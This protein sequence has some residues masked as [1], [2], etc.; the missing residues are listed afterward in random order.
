MN[1][2][3]P[4]TFEISLSVL[5]H[6]GRSLYRSFATVLGEAISN[7]WDADAKDVHIYVDRNKNSFF[8][9]DNGTGMTADDFQN[10]FLKIGYSKR[11]AGTKFSLGGRPFIGRKGI[12]KLA[13]LSCADKITVISKVEGGTYIG[14]VVDNSKLDQAIT[15]DLKPQEYPLEEWKAATFAKYTPG[16]RHGT[17][18]HFE[19]VKEGIRSSFPVL[20]KI[21]A[22]YFR[23]SLLDPSFNIFLDGK[24]ITHKYLKDLADRTEFLWT[25]GDHHD[26]YVEALK[27]VF[28]KGPDHHE[29]KQL[30]IAGVA[31][32]IA[33]VEKPMALKIMDTEERVGIDL[34]VNGRLRERDI[35]KHTPTARVAESY[36]YGQIHFDGLDDATDRFTSSREGIVADDPKYTK[37][38]ET[39]RNT[40]LKVVEDWDKWR[41]KHREVGDP[42]NQRLTKKQR[43]SL[44]LYGAVSKEYDLSK[45]SANKGKVAGWVDG[46][47]GDAA[48][49]FE[50]Y[51]DCFVSENLMR[52]Y[53]K[54]KKLPL[55]KEA[56]AEVGQM[57]QRE[58][59]SKGR[60]NI[61]IPIRRN[62]T[63][64]SY[65]SMDHLANLVDKTKD[66]AKEAGLSRDAREY[67]PIRDAVAHTALLTHAAKTK[68]STVGE[69]IKGRVKTILSKGK[70]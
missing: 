7:S 15:E 6:L 41:I 10:K 37:F 57:K 38:L 47:S 19:R 16:H 60:G 62:P 42:D 21:I 25:I 56:K 43:A 27:S 50:S 8:I 26:P 58:N 1:N 20:A 46:L 34:F 23:F 70:R 64:S 65:L 69:N 29:T 33:S 24:K 48:F 63:D 68:L 44:G 49:N 3:E 39:F 36:L 4:F 12:G 66:P 9:K 28:S 5:N 67:K 45:S 17:I 18:I 13:L 32:F 35:L 55:S 14:G 11:K 31:G 30:E 51:A 53:I 22:L 40:I 54:E 2:R 52:K 59:D 61:S